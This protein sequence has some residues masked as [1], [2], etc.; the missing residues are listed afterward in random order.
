MKYMTRK[1]AMS[2]SRN[3]QQSNQYECLGKDGWAPG[4]NILT[5]SSDSGAGVDFSPFSPMFTL[6]FFFCSWFFFLFSFCFWVSLAVGKQRFGA[7]PPPAGMDCGSGCQS[8]SKCFRILFH[9]FTTANII[10]RRYV[11][12]CYSDVYFPFPLCCCKFPHC[13]D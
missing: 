11:F 7:L 13:V 4:L 9:Y 10:E 12:I 6:L 3:T 5:S 8:K 2:K 1:K